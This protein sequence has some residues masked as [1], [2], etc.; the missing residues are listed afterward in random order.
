VCKRNVFL[1][2]GRYKFHFRGAKGAEKAIDMITG[3]SLLFFTLSLENN[4]IS[5]ACNLFVFAMI[6]SLTFW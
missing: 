1:F 3:I 5:N 6:I 4:I 2:Q